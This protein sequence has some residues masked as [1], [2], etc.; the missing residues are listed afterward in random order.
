[1]VNRLPEWISKRLAPGRKPEAEPPRKARPTRTHHQNVGF[2]EDA[3]QGLRDLEARSVP[4]GVEARSAYA[5]SYAHVDRLS[6]A[7][8]AGGGLVTDDQ[9]NQR[10]HY[11]GHRERLRQ[12]FLRG[13]HD[14][15]PDYELLELLLFNAIE[16]IDVKPLAKRLL[17]EFGD[18]S[19]VVSAS[20]HRLSKVDGTTD[21]VFFQL[22]IAEAMAQR[23]AKAKAFQR[24]VVSS[25]DALIAYCRTAMAHR[26]TEQFRVLYLDRKNKV[27]ADEAQASGTVDHVP[28]YPREVAKRA[29]ELNASAIILVHNHPSGDTTPSAPDISMTEQI[30]AACQTIGVTVHDHVII[31]RETDFSFRS[32][33]LMI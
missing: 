6:P 24:D 12:R 15:M 32:N 30:E 27:I 9:G 31:G 7:N 19:G 21:K 1:M 14:P 11:H 26:D 3:L 17:A 33:G 25:W 13:G 5:P 18:L 4:A 20:E 2:S 23:M 8:A 22:K 29:L 28:V 16:R 10:P